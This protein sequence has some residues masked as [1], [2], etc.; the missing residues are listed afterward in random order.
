M[1]AAAGRQDARD[2]PAPVFAFTDG[3]CPL[4]G[5]PGARAS[6]AALVTGGQ[7]GAAVIRGEV[8]P[9]EYAFVDE[10]DPERGVHETQT[11]VAPSNNRGELL[12]IIFAF[13]ALLRGRAV[14]RV[15]LASDSE[16]S[17][18]TLLEWLPARLKKG[19]E[20]ELKN[21]D[22]VWIAWRLLGCLRKQAANV[23]LTHVR[24]HQKPP[25]TTA[26]SRE[27]FLWKGNDMADKHAAAA[28]GEKATFAVEVLDAPAALRELATQP[29]P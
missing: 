1:D 15:E 13:L 14:G 2:G 9:T 3:S 10:D 16:I 27:R 24:S 28:L 26:P 18:R 12:G 21:F 22:L 7:F 25:P 8:C 4:N 11:L 23:V 19:T 20:R 5:K 29:L 17:V 6:F